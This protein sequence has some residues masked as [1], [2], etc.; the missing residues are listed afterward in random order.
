[1]VAGCNTR[2]NRGHT[3]SRDLCR[4]NPRKLLVR[5]ETDVLAG[6]SDAG[7]LAGLPVHPEMLP[8]RRTNLVRSRCGA[9]SVAVSAPDRRGLLV[10]RRN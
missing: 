6:L 7:V 2:R 9:A 4:A 8:G 1:L 5:S 10:R 3:A